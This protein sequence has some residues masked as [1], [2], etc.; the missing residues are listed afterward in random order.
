MELENRILQAIIDVS[1]GISTEAA[2]DALHSQIQSLMED[3]GQDEEA[4]KWFDLRLELEIP[5]PTP[6]PSEIPKTPLLGD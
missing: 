3:L 6:E 1:K 5:I 2:I 4:L